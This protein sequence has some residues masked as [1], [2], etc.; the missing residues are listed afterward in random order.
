MTGTRNK[1]RGLF[2][3]AL[4]VFSVFA[5]TIA[6]AGSAAAVDTVGNIGLTANDGGD[7][8]GAPGASLGS[9]QEDTEH[10]AD[11]EPEPELNFDV[12]GIN[13]GNS[14]DE[15]IVITLPGAFTVGDDLDSDG[16]ALIIENDPSGN[17]EVEEVTDRRITL[18]GD[19]SDAGSSASFRIQFEAEIGSV[20]QDTEADVEVEVEDSGGTASE[21][22]TVFI[23]DNL[24]PPTGEGFLDDDEF[25]SDEYV[26]SGD[27]FYQGQQLVTTV[28]GSIGSTNIEAGDA[29][30]L[31]EFDSSEDDGLGT[32]VRELTVNRN[33]QLG[34]D[35]STLEGRY[36]VIAPDGSPV[37]F[38]DAGNPD[39]AT[40]VASGGDGSGNSVSADAFTVELQTL[41]A[42]FAEE[43]AAEDDVVDY[44][45]NSNRA[46]YIAVLTPQN[47]NI[48]AEDLNAALSRDGEVVE[49]DVDDDGD[50]EEHV[51]FG[52]QREN[53]I[54]TFDFDEA[55]IDG[56]IS[57]AATSVDTGVADS[58][59][60]DI[61][62]E[63]DADVEIVDTNTL[64]P[65]DQIRQDR[66]DFVRFGLELD[67]TDTAT[68]RFGN[69]DQNYISEIVVED[70][71]DDGTI[72]VT[73]NTF[74]AGRYDEST[75]GTVPSDGTGLS[76]ETSA[77]AD[78]Q[79]VYAVG[80]DDDLNDVRLITPDANDQDL[81]LT[82]VIEP[83]NYPINAYAGDVDPDDEDANDR[84]LAIITNRPDPQAISRV[85]PG[86]T[87]PEEYNNESVDTRF[88]RADAQVVAEE[89][90]VRNTVAEGD[91]VVIEFQVSGI[92]GFFDGEETLVTET[93]T[94]FAEDNVVSVAGVD[95]AERALG[96]QVRQTPENRVEQEQN[97]EAK[98]LFSSPSFENLEDGGVAVSKPFEGAQGSDVSG[99]DAENVGVYT[100]AFENK[101]YVA[102]GTSGPDIAQRQDTNEFTGVEDGDE[103][104]ANLTIDEENSLLGAEDDN[105]VASTTFEIV[106]P[107]VELDT[108]ESG[109]DLD[110]DGE[111]DEERI[112]VENTENANIT[113]TSTL[114]PGTEVDIT[115]ET[116]TFLSTETVEVGDDGTFGASFPFGNVT[117]GTNFTVE[118]VAERTDGSTVSDNVN[119]GDTPDGVITG[120]QASVSISDQ[121]VQAGSSEQVIT[122]DSVS[123][124]RGGFVTIHDS[125]LLD[126]DAVGSVRGTSDFLAP[127]E[128][129]DVEVTL[130]TPYESGGSDTIIAMPHLDTNGNEQYDF[131]SSGGQD[132][133]PYTTADGSP[134][135]ADAEL[136]IEAE[137]TTTEE[138]TTST[139]EPTTTSTPEPTTTSTPEPTTTTT[140]GQPGFT[141]IVALIALVAAAL[142]AARRRS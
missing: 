37:Q 100:N 2:L 28:P 120:P 31:Y 86:D 57:V 46:E 42:E 49:F 115:V 126:G 105:E 92:F 78:E 114:A 11:G 7:T 26:L 10:S 54:L 47:D 141:A 121:T 55:D 48:S 116:D 123:L 61:G 96:V 12:S 41:D 119:S 69:S 138:T 70:D 80:D 73:L 89:S 72:N 23:N 22:T 111:A 112:V 93:S 98:V 142:L 3:A 104:F 108:D 101:F 52:V 63:E 14:E 29:F 45:V 17:L 4:M 84:A 135:V 62:E 50:D 113:G 53:S 19:L 136:T 59:E 74:F 77:P 66:G 83:G 140:S 118:A 44:T 43:S 117:A 35:T 40:V 68:V 90:G 56:T 81:L 1:V 129:E 67:N 64:E 127:G 87:N 91:N 71:D 103:F 139:P 6:L 25:E 33:S 20:N 132:D 15:T 131:V 107:E 94:A 30:E 128:Y 79:L 109:L 106:E 88:G 27:T 82:D 21:A 97:Q 122:V 32:F 8:I 102:I 137:E 5:G 51:R 34:I 125:T 18:T 24:E 76:F 134:V 39:N 124:S 58:D 85:A 110:G 13:T 16:D 36:V 133:A 95:P 75:E 130:G 65:R 9:L 99:G 38:D 60:L